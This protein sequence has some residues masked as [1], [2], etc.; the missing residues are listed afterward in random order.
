MINL[1]KVRESKNISQKELAAIM[2]VGQSTVSMWET[3]ETT[4]RMPKLL[5]LC[6]VLNCSL[7]ELIGAENIEAAQQEVI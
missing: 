2:K 3:G 7:D 1:R 4:P 6:K 5:K